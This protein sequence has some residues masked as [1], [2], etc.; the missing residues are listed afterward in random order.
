MKM[1]AKGLLVAMFLVVLVMSTGIFSVKANGKEEAI[2][3]GLTWLVSRQDPTTGAWA[4]DYYE[5]SETAFAVVKL[6]EHAKRTLHIDPFSDDY[7]YKQ[8][9]TAG[10]KYIFEHAVSIDIN[11]EPAGNPDVNLVNGKGIYFTSDT[12]AN[13][14]R[15]LYETGIVMM[16]LEASCHPTFVVD[17]PGSPVHGWSYLD[18]MRD[19]VDYVAWA[20]QDSGSGRGGWRYCPFDNGVVVNPGGGLTLGGADN[21][22]SQWPVLGLMSAEAWLISAPGWVKS[23]LL[24]NWLAYSQNANGGFGYDGPGGTDIDM[25]ASGLI[26]FTYCGLETTDARWDNAR[27]YIGDYW[28]TGGQQNVG[29]LYAMYAVM[30]AAMTALPDVV[31]TFGDHDWQEEYDAWLL[32]NQAGDGYWTGPY[33]T[34]EGR[35]VLGT[36]WGLLILQKVAPPPPAI[37]LD[38]EPPVLIDLT[39]PVG[40]EWH[41]LYPVYCNPYQ[42]ISWEDTDGNGIIDYCD[43]IKLRNTGTGDVAEYH[44]EGVTVTIKVTN[45]DTGESMYIEFE[46]DIDEFPFTAPICTMWHEVYPEYCRWYHL[47]SWEDTDLSGHINPSDQIDM[48]PI[49][50]TGPVEWYHVD[51]VK[52]DILV[53]RKPTPPPP[54]GGLHILTLLDTIKALT[55]WIA[56]ALIAAASIAVSVKTWTRKE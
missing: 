50:P 52:T 17:A 7:I 10:L 20:Q 53:T 12:P 19:A 36:T 39:D 41:E 56:M 29:D 35:R 44:V 23:E 22:V 26:Q 8:N 18:V 11:V 43:Q 45:K 28:S 4:L 13:S 49:A 25:T 51:E 2:E 15:P 30:K 24:N 3:K 38:A 32:A 40:T 16:A 34:T 33:G 54:V 21:S 9:V 14:R 55:P 27:S 37:H 47:S 48:T 46:G 42:L 5:V 31:W 6:C 1:N